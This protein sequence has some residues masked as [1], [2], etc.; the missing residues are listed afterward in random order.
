SLPAVEKL[1]KEYDIKIA[2][3]CHGRE[4]KYF[5]IPKTVLDAVKGMDPRMGLCMDIGHATR[6]G[7]DVVEDIATGGSRLFDLHFKDLKSKTDKDSQCEVGEGVLPIVAILKQLKKVGY[8][9]SVNLEYETN[10]E[11]PLP[12]AQRSIGY[13]KGVLAGL[14][15]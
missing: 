12:G 15:G 11:N 3:H 2:I 14:V 1:A 5:P 10:A 7:A 9:G 13:M 6:G 4:D 8:K